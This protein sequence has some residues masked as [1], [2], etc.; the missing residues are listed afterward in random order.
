MSP[1]WKESEGAMK[2]LIIFLLLLFASLLP[3]AAVLAQNA[4]VRFSYDENGNRIR[5]VLELKKTEEN[6][7]NV[8][9][10]N[11]FLAETTE[12]LGTTRLSLYPNPTHDK[13]TLELTDSFT[14]H[15]NAVLTTVAGAVIEDIRLNGLQHDFDLTVQPAGVYLLRITSGDETRT[16]KI[17]KH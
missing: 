1:N 10:E 5:R 8:E 2:N 16:W 7:K 11:S 15:I 12:Q 6:G 3:S 14:N 13:V 17:V 4:H 9:A